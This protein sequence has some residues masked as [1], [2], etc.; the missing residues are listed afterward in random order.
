MLLYDTVCDFLD[1]FEILSVVDIA[2]EKLRR[3]ILAKVFEVLSE[4]VHK[5]NCVSLFSG[6]ISGL[7]KNCSLHEMKGTKS[8][9][10]ASTQSLMS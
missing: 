10:G 3:F 6:R 4:D 2:I 8:N 1:F 9:F 7:V 5:V